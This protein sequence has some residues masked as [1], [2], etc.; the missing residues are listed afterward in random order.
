MPCARCWLHVSPV[1][2][3]P[4]LG[5]F[6]V[7]WAD[8]TQLLPTGGALVGRRYM[9]LAL[10]LPLAFPREELRLRLLLRL[11]LRPRV[12]LPTRTLSAAA[13]DNVL[14]P[15]FAYPSYSSA[16]AY[17]SAYPSVV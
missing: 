7:F 8:E 12:V 11:L 17:P 2:C 3:C 16:S 14:A 13:Y 6:P 5:C 10:G 15:A 1:S 4:H 9:A